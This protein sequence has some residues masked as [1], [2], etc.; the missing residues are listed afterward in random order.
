MNKINKDKAKQTRRG[1]KIAFLRAYVKT[2]KSS[3]CLANTE[4]IETRDRQ[5]K[6]ELMR[7]NTSTDFMFR[8]VSS[9][10]PIFIQYLNKTHKRFSQE[11]SSLQTHT[12][13]YKKPVIGGK[14]LK[15]KLQAERNGKMEQMN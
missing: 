14:M 7:C 4:K 1:K 11:D 2:N 5:M 8:L 13:T 12:H 15:E 3:L 10:I 9:K 6:L